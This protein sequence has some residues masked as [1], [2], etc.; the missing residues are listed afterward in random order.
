MA[1]G[2]DDGAL[3]LY[4]ISGPVPSPLPNPPSVPPLLSLLQS[5]G[6]GAPSISAVSLSAD[7]SVVVAGGGNL[8][9][10][11]QRYGSSWLPRYQLTGHTATVRSVAASAGGLHAHSGG[12]DGTVRAWDLTLGVEAGPAMPIGGSSLC[13]TLVAV[14]ADGRSVAAA[15]DGDGMIRF[16]ASW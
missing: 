16:W 2:T 6:G 4:D 3:Q 8:V 5:P 14:G 9:L 11:W 1:V 13:A 10:I 15:G 12:C 7:G